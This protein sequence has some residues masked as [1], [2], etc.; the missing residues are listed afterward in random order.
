MRGLRV[1]PFERLLFANET[2]AVGSHRLPATDPRFECYG[3][4]S[5]FLLV[6]PRTSTML[7]YAGSDRFVGSPAVA[8]LYNRGQEYR[9]RRISEEGDFCDWF[10]IAPETLREVVAKFDRAAADSD[11]PLTFTH[12]RVEPRDYIEQRTVV[13]HL[14][15]AGESDPLFVEEMTLG[16][17]ARLLARAYD[18]RSVRVTRGQEELARAAGALLGRTFTRNLPLSRIAAEVGCS[19]FHLARSFKETMGMTLHQHR[20][21]LRLHASLA[22]LRD[23]DRDL[24]TIALDL[25]FG[26]HSHFTMTFRRRFGVTPSRYRARATFS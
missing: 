7:E 25:G 10:A 19:P 22:L 2:L 23:T 8:P 12:V 21:L 17:L 5:A 1:L 15:G 13:D 26:D 14:A 24:S 6:F 18:H 4:T 16:V 3:P 11:R 20:L 9:R